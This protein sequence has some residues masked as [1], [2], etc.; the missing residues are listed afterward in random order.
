MDFRKQLEDFRDQISDLDHS[1]NEKLPMSE[2]DKTFPGLQ[3][4]I[5]D[6]SHAITGVR[7]RLEQNSETLE[8]HRRDLN[9][10][11]DHTKRDELGILQNRLLFDEL[12]ER[13]G[14][15]E[16]MIIRRARTRRINPWFLGFCGVVAGFI[17][18]KR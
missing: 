4:Q 12:E 17:I 16:G 10:L 1:I 3:S 9:E 5:D 6:H 7:R 18:A 8:C 14:E 15:L 11:F 2:Y 13:I